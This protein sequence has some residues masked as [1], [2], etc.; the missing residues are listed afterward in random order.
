MNIRDENEPV[1]TK[2]NLFKP[3]YEI[4]AKTGSSD[5]QKD[6]ASETSS[7]SSATVSVSSRHSSPKKKKKPS[8]D[9]SGMNFANPSRVNN[10]DEA[11]Q[12][13]SSDSDKDSY[14][15]D[16]DNGSVQNSRPTGQ[17]QGAYPGQFA[18]NFENCSQQ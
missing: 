8:R 7:Q 1:V 14:Y 17:F 10:D 4:K 6:R 15:S 13:D 12:D 3:N 2:A 16:S 9:Y 5:K 18:D 11:S